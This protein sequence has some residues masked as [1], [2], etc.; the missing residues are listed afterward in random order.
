MTTHP[1]PRPFGVVSAEARAALASP[2]IAFPRSESD[3]Y[4]PGYYRFYQLDC[5]VLML[6][7]LIAALPAEE[8]AT[9][10]LTMRDA[11]VLAEHAATTEIQR[12]LNDHERKLMHECLRD[13]LA[14][15]LNVRAVERDRLREVI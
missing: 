14:S 2:L 1:N 11:D 8:G 4:A 7:W 9:S 15:R 10:P 13:L 3:S 6:R 5:R 12:A